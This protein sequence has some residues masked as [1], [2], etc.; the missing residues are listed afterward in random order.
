MSV[1]KL[2]PLAYHR[3]LAAYLETAE[4]AIWE[5]AR[6][7]EVQERQAAEMREA[8]LRNTYRMEAESHPEVHAACR[9][10]M[11]TL[12]IE[13][14]VTLYQAADG[15]MNA[16][17]CFIPGEI[18]M[19]FF[20]PILERLSG[21]ELSALLG[22]EL[23][24]YRLWTVDEGVH[25]SASRI[26]DQSLSY[27]NAAP[28]HRETARLLS[29]YTELYA[30]RGGALVCDAVG[31][32]IA[33]LVK[34][35]TGMSNVDPEAYLRQAEELD[36]SVTRSEGMSHPEV[37]LR[38]RALKKWW[39]GEADAE[40]WIDEKLR[41][42]LSLQSLDLLR[43][44]DLTAL[45]RAFLSSFVASL[46]LASEAVS[47]QARTYFPDLSGQ[48]ERIDPA[49]IAPERIDDSTREYFVAL[50]LDC[51]MADADARDEILAAAAM[52]ARD[53]GAGDQLAAALK[54]DLKW[55]RAA[56]DRLLARA[57]K[58]A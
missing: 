51:A 20:G 12:G 14:A 15:A 41:G 29:L 49:R 50:M 9:A 43:Q 19:V 37:F 33:V 45:T 48:E 7:A 54:R 22:H 56:A 36:S 42:K 5:W 32:A 18:H 25:Y 3:D 13:A 46:P 58:A 40:E 35:M 10:A 39:A 28:S 55:T 30:D 38:A 17:L 4:P 2:E 1:H 11:E 24:H 26:L 57:P 27:D 23:S 16:S 44:R 52:V 53:M 21:E 8:M 47:A 6:S 31:P 34:T